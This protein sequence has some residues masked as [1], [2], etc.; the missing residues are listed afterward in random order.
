MALSE[1]KDLKGQ[2]F[3][4]I[5]FN[6]IKNTLINLPDAIDDDIVSEILQ[7]AQNYFGRNSTDFLHAYTDLLVESCNSRL[8]RSLPNEKD[9]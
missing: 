6:Y 7:T 1:E 3:V 5:S 8:S 2:D 4:D 9:A